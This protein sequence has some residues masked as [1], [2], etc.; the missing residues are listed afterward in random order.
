MVDLD[1][2]YNEALATKTHGHSVRD[3]A[4]ISA[5]EL[6]HEASFLE[7][8]GKVKDAEHVYEAALKIPQIRRADGDKAKLTALTRLGEAGF[9]ER[10]ERSQEAETFS[11]RAVNTPNKKAEKSSGTEIGSLSDLGL[12]LI[13][14]AVARPYNATIG[15]IAP[16]IDVGEYNHNSIA[17]KVGDFWGSV[18]DVIALS[19]VTGWGV[20]KGLG[21][22]AERGLVSASMMGNPT[23]RQR[24][25]WERQ[26][27]SMEAF[28]LPAL[29]QI[30]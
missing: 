21:W 1:T 22:G 16:K 17:A 28:S 9:L 3:I 19:K 25:R 12:G 15:L 23:W 8:E 4:K 6:L 11:D 5:M 27:P 14:S 30:A 20:G 18:A 10:S 26:E 29:R 24:S 2:S 7:R 13:D